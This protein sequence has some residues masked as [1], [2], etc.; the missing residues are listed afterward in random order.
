VAKNYSGC[1]YKGDLGG[2]AKTS[3]QFVKAQFKQFRDQNEEIEGKR[4]LSASP[5]S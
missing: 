1:V 5:L 4:N 3:P 2:Q